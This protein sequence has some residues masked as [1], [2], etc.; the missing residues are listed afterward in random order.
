M[1][2]ISFWGND[3]NYYKMTIVYIVLALL[4]GVG[5]GFFA[6][7]SKLWL[8]EG[9]NQATT[10]TIYLLIFSMGLAV[11]VNR[12]LISN[13]F[14]IGFQSMFIAFT[15]MLGSI[16]VVLFVYSMGRWLRKKYLASNEKS[17]V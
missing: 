14:S 4:I 9:L 12:K 16:A 11:G 10:V 6:I 5:I 1:V 15:A 2:F 8:K 7:R 3:L 17:I 13:I